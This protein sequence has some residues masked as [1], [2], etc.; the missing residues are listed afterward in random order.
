MFGLRTTVHG[1]NH[2]G[3]SVETIKT[4]TNKMDSIHIQRDTVNVMNLPINEAAEGAVEGVA[5]GE[6]EGVAVETHSVI[7]IN[8]VMTTTTETAWNWM[9]EG[10]TA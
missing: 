8:V 6:G 1:V 9:T 5:E 7:T 10:T 4:I 2:S 3:F